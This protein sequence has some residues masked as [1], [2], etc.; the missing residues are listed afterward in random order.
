MSSSEE[1]SKR[2]E[3]WLS[4]IEKDFDVGLEEVGHLDAYLK[5]EFDALD[6]SADSNPED[7]YGRVVKLAAVC[8]HAARKKDH[9]VGLLTRYLHRFISVMR[10]VEK[11]MGAASFSITAS[12]P[13]D[14]SI[15]LTF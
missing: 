15:S 12:F 9:L 4:G 6:S 11:D 14:L 8:G 13:F 5:K 7:A 10:K 1:F 2:V 3:D